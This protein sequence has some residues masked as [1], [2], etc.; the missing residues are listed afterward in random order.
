MAGKN[1]AKA[2][3]ER[4]DYTRLQNLNALFAVIGSVSTQEE[5]LQLQ[6]TL[7]FMRENDDDRHMSSNSFEHCIEQV[8]RFHFPNKRTFRFTHWNARRQSIEP[9]WVRASVLDFVQSFQASSRGII[10][11]SGLRET[12][13]AGKDGLL[14]RKR[15]IRNSVASSK[16]LSF[17]MLA[18]I[19]I[20]PYFFLISVKFS[21]NTR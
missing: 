15:N 8:V 10:L 11:V 16:T 19:R 21:G 6:R 18:W 14:E 7:S 9:L 3:T 1:V 17:A 12:L 4:D 2:A 13:K 20:Y 5:T